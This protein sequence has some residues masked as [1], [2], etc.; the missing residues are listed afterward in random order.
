MTCKAYVINTDTGELT[1]WTEMGF[2]RVWQINGVP[3]LVRPDGVYRVDETL[4][5][6]AMASI[7]LAPTRMGTDLGKSLRFVMADGAGD[8]VVTP[9]YDGVVG[10][11]YVGELGDGRGV[12]VG[13]G[14][15]ARWMSVKLAGPAVSLSITA[16]RL[17]F[18]EL[19]RKV[20]T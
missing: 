20:V 4:D 15:K 6:S 1:Q 12:K 17:Y 11:D 9:I 14:N 8:V 5:I 2:A 19:T 16:L 10:E 13:R 3:F 18:N 7:Q